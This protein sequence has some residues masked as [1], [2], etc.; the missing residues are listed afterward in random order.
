MRIDRIKFVTEIA[1][2]DMT[3]VELAKK[4]GVNRVTLS[5]IKCGKSCTPEVAQKIANGLGIDLNKLL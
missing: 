1:K 2:Q 5:N 4:S 3:L